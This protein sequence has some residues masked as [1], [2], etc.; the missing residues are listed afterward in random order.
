MSS[1]N[2]NS[3]QSLSEGS[4]TTMLLLILRSSLAAAFVVRVA[5][6]RSSVVV[7]PSTPGSEA[8]RSS[9]H[10]GAPVPPAMAWEEEGGE[11]ASGDFLVTAGGVFLRLGSI[12]SHGVPTRH[13]SP[14]LTFS[15]LLID[16]SSVLAFSIA[17]AWASSQSFASRQEYEEDDR[18]I[19]FILR[20]AS[21][22]LSSAG[23]MP[24]FTTVLRRAAFS[25][26]MVRTALTI[27]RRET[28]ACSLSMLSRT[29]FGTR[30]SELERG[31][32]LPDS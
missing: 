22:I 1:R 5:I 10:D 28:S 15:P 18:K 27:S 26:C 21:S 24:R 7:V 13:M 31:D 30:Y 6:L 25:F 23:V 17:R 19:V 29:Y 12:E 2:N 11:V 32:P 4:S 9:V 14:G 20:L 3:S 16:S 8:E